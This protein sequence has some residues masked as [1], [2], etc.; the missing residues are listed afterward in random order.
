VLTLVRAVSLFMAVAGGGLGLGLA[1]LFVQ[2]GDPTGGLLP[3]FV[4]PARDVAIGAALMG[5]LGLLAGVVPA[6]GAMRL[7][8]T[9]AL[10]RA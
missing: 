9:D 10:R 6:M 8:I 5:L 3:I 2:Q 7:R 1:W 4:L